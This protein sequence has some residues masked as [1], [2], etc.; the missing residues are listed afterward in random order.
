M[1]T[2]DRLGTDR[3]CD[4][5][6]SQEMSEKLLQQGITALKAGQRAEAYRLLKQV[7]RLDPSS[8]HGWLWLSGAVDTDEQ[9]RFCLLQVL[10]I[11][12]RNAIASR[13][14]EKLGPGNARSPLDEEHISG[15]QGQQQ[16]VEVNVDKFCPNCNAFNPHNNRF[17]DQCG[18]SLDQPSKPKSESARR[19]PPPTG[20]STN[21]ERK[22]STTLPSSVP[23]QTSGLESGSSRFSA[24]RLIIGLGA[25]IVIIAGFLPWAQTIYL[26]SR[27]SHMGISSGTGLFSTAMGILAL[28][29]AFAIEKD[30]AANWVALLLTGASSFSAWSVLSGGW[31]DITNPD[32]YF[33]GAPSSIGPYVVF[34]GTAL[35]AGSLLVPGR[36]KNTV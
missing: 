17:C 8:E 2:R 27:A 9:R 31:R 19:V 33:G 29:L 12:R 5:Q 10:S 4:N 24:K 22:P 1:D 36:E 20:V 35:V 7:V 11:N 3:F 32:A 13:G 21:T 26:F 23:Q 30:S 18:S 28:V 16:T 6:E 14:L 34:V 25:C 15:V